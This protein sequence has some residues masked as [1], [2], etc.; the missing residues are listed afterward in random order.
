MIS[1]MTHCNEDDCCN[2]VKSKFQVRLVFSIYDIDKWEMATTIIDH[3]C[4][5]K[6]L[7]LV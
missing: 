4:I 2:R 3:G 6:M 7:F 5:S 1:I